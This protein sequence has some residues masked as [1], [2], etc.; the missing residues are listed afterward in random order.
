VQEFV[1]ANPREQYRSRLVTVASSLG[2]ETFD[3]TPTMLASTGDGL[4]YF[5]PW[6]GHLSASGHESVARELAERINAD[7]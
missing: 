4:R 7:P 5:I 3:A 6:D 1:A 2:L